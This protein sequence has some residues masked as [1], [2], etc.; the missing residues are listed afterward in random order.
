MWRSSRNENEDIIL[1]G[2]NT[3]TS[4]D[5]D[6]AGTSRRRTSSNDE[7]DEDTIQAKFIN[8]AREY[9]QIKALVSTRYSSKKRELLNNTTSYS[10][11]LSY[12]QY[13]AKRLK[14]ECNVKRHDRVGI[15]IPG[16]GASPEFLV[17]MLAVLCC[18]AAYV[19]IDLPPNPTLIQEEILEESR[20]KA[21][22]RTDAADYLQ[23]SWSVLDKYPWIQLESIST[24]AQEDFSSSTLSSSGQAVSS[25]NDGTY[26]DDNFHFE[27][28]HI[29][30]DVCVIFTSGS[31]GK[32]KSV[33]LSHRGV[34]CRINWSARITP[35]VPGKDSM[36]FQLSTTTLGGIM[37]PLTGLLQGCTVF[38]ARPSLTVDIERF[39]DQLSFHRV[40]FIISMPSLLKDLLAN[41]GGGTSTT[42]FLSQLKAVYL[43][44]EAY[45]NELL[46]EVAQASPAA[47]LVNLYG[48]TETTG[49]TIA[50]VYSRRQNIKDMVVKMGLPTDNTTA[51]LLDTE[52]K[53]ALPLKT[54]VVGEL[55]V[56]GAGMSKGYQ[57]ESMNVERS[58]VHEG[59]LFFQT[60]DL[61]EFCTD[62]HEG[63]F[64]RYAGRSDRC[65]KISGFRVELDGV[66]NILCTLPGVAKA[67]VITNKTISATDPDA[68]AQQVLDSNVYFASQIIAFVTPGT[69]SGSAIRSRCLDLL[70]KHALPVKIY[71]LDELPM[72]ISGKIDRKALNKY[73]FDHIS[74]QSE[75][76]N[77][78]W[79]DSTNQQRLHPSNG[80]Q[81]QDTVHPFYLTVQNA[82]W[83]ALGDTCEADTSIFL[84]GATSTT[85]V[86]IV[87]SLK[88]LPIS[89]ADIYE[90]KTP[91]EIAMHLFEN[92]QN[93]EQQEGRCATTPTA[94]SQFLLAH[95]SKSLLGFGFFPLLARTIIPVMLFKMILGA[96]LPYLR[97]ENTNL[98]ILNFDVYFHRDI[99]TAELTA[100][101]ENAMAIFPV[102]RASFQGGFF[103]EKMYILSNDD[104]SVPLTVTSAQKMKADYMQARRRISYGR[105][106]LVEFLYDEMNSKLVI[107]CDHTISDQSSL[108]ILV[109]HIVC[110]CN[111]EIGV[112]EQRP[113]SDFS[114]W[115]YNINQEHLKQKSLEKTPCCIRRGDASFRMEEKKEVYGVSMRRRFL[116][117]APFSIRSSEVFHTVPFSLSSLPKGVSPKAAFLTFFHAMVTHFDGPTEI[118]IIEVKDLRLSPFIKGFDN[119]FGAM[120][121]I[122]STTLKYLP[123]LSLIENMTNLMATLKDQ[124]ES[125]SLWDAVHGPPTIIRSSGWSINFIDT[126][127]DVTHGATFF[128]HNNTIK[129]EL[130]SGLAQRDPAILV[131]TF[132]D[133]DELSF[134]FD[135]CK[136]NLTRCM[137]RSMGNCLVHNILAYNAS[138]GIRAGR[139]TSPA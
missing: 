1:S 65:V 26:T 12:V 67:A 18:G 56:A 46:Q 28:G 22:I 104:I 126:M 105:S 77:N 3:V 4:S 24:L 19:P 29:D 49:H 116:S 36:L 137:V 76:V 81:T 30:D 129:E 122:C 109:K 92:T 115:Q 45:S 39:A 103:Q 74:N 9:P 32:S 114:Q 107:L 35:M 53:I 44:G 52:H 101:I 97:R 31:T 7:K 73:I 75:L 72:T 102:L 40:N 118:S 85:V 83:K 119:T 50:H 124:E 138:M 94:A 139:D 25:Q 63:V 117:F 21:L 60:G 86:Q 127:D 55:C 136:M 99:T 120:F 130:S 128:R 11:L 135:F 106:D 48:M 2:I 79:N 90:L 34:R 121:T 38:V 5:D 61:V 64:L 62:Q 100:A 57:D 20:C 42:A 17:S 113:Y 95:S 23:Q 54:S 111:G 87:R 68:T 13:T 6:G 91:T 27:E 131:N 134:H 89:A 125:L 15:L 123:S 43:T 51:I 8:I 78:S 84:V 69:L 47:T 80:N 37:L 112:T 82:I 108:A 10:E 33:I 66:E 71:A 70:P 59:E 133:G 93:N 132:F 110:R 96:L 58:F 88:P 14:E 98:M 16:G 41:K